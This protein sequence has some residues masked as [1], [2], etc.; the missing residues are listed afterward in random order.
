MEAVK[1]ITIDIRYWDGVQGDNP[2][3][4]TLEDAGNMVTIMTK[5]IMDPA[6]QGLQVTVEKSHS[7]EFM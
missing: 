5:L 4:V 1:A 6:V 7:G 3:R 2:S